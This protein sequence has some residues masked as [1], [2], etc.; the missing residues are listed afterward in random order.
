[1]LIYPH[2]D[3]IAFDMGPLKIH[4]YGLMYLL[5]FLLGWLL[6]QYRVK[7]FHLP[8]TKDEIIDLIFYS[9]LGVIFGGRLGYMVFYNFANFLHHPLLVFKIWEGGMSFHGGLL[10]VIIALWFWI[11]NKPYKTL[12]MATDLIVPVV[13][14]GLAAGRLGN[15]LQG[16]LWGRVTDVS[17]GMVY[18][19]VDQSP[20]HP[21]QIYEFLLE[22]L[23]LFIVIWLYAEKPRPRLSVSAFF[24]LSYG[25]IRC[26]CEFFRQPD[27]QWGY[28]AWGWLTMGQ[29]LSLPMIIVGM[30]VLWRVYHQHWSEL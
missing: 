17:W 5:S 20:R 24:L 13:P 6:V 16:E 15:F 4:W 19:Y 3:P 30:V 12:G 11:R 8:W 14:L 21:S 10:G 29:L 28:M 22:G 26:F 9:A 27:P 7:K 25:I 23:F 1:M 2:I 18:P